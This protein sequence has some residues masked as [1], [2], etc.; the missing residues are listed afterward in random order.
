MH[1]RFYLVG[2][3]ATLS[4]MLFFNLFSRWLGAAPFLSRAEEWGTSTQPVL[5]LNAQNEFHIAIFSDL[6]YGEEENGW[7]IGQDV[8]STRVM[9]NIL[10]S[11]NPDFV[12]LNGDLITGE[13]TFL[14][15]STHYVDVIVTPLE[16]HKVRWAST[17]GNHDSQF[18]LSREALFIEEHKHSLS[19]TQH[20]PKGI[21]G[22][23]NYYLPL[24]PTQG[25]TPVAI[26]WFFDSQGGAPF[27]ASLTSETIPNWV[28]PTIVSWFNSTKSALKT[29]WGKDLPSLAFVHIP[30]TAFLTVQQTLLPNYGEES[31]HFP[32]LNDDVP[33][34]A[35]GDGSQDIPFMQSLVNT[36]GT[37]NGFGREIALAAL[38]R[39]D[40]VIATARNTSSIQDLAAKGAHTIA[41]DL[42]SPASSIKATVQK[43]I[44]DFGGVDI[45]F[46]NAGQGIVGAVE[47]TSDEELR[48][49]FD[50]NFFGHVAVTRAVLP[51]MRAKKSGTIG[52]NG[53]AAGWLT[54]PG[55]SAY[56]ATKHAL[57]GLS[58]SLRTE[59]APF[60][61]R[62]AII[63]PGYFRTNMMKLA[64]A[65]GG[66][67]ANRLEAYD[68]LTGAMVQMSKDFVG[69]QPGDPVKGA[70]VIVDAL[71]GEG[72]FEGKELPARLLLGKDILK[73][74]LATVEGQMKGLEEWREENMLINCVYDV[75][76]GAIEMASPTMTVTLS[77]IATAPPYEATSCT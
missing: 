55:A 34:A 69:K 70:K 17:Y 21:P 46:N 16:Q 63:E 49:H 19:Y 23:T 45:L 54:Y 9:N 42:S 39:G 60:N 40:K 72:V 15:N 10:S 33:L 7:G 75:Y 24:Y 58:Q 77:G 14:T 22:I 64:A 43:A 1:L 52:F 71:K 37:S 68:P 5:R 57:A 65:G 4:T 38:A 11:E 2:A 32:G 26:L 6:H 51:H 41:L 27:Q 35:E 53:S 74:V 44:E 66:V 8:N 61:I 47:E 67:V 76:D 25:E 56:C 3:I 62:V 12:V 59:L 73:A 13:N 28:D 18:N 50:V 29:K 30:P 31:A 48:E 36:P 20:S